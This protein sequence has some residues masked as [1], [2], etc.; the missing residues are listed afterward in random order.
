MPEPNEPV[1]PNP[2]AGTPDPGTPP[3]TPATPAAPVPGEPEPKP[4]LISEKEEEKGKEGDEKTPEGAP[5]KYEDFKFP[6]GI[7]LDEGD[8]TEFTDFAKSNKFTQETAQAIVDMSIKRDKMNALKNVEA[9]NKVREDWVKQLGEDTEFGGAKQGETIERVKRV[10]RTYGDKELFESLEQSGY[11]DNYH[12]LKMLAKIDIATGEKS[13]VN[14][15]ATKVEEKT[16][17]KTMFPNMN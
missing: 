12:L 10:L 17:A 5:E 7:E 1:Q 4:L 13:I 14:G 3:A 8:L 11:G 16:L 6:D 2:E 9:W 15:D